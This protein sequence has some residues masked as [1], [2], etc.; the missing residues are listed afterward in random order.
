MSR[1][2]AMLEYRRYTNITLPGICCTALHII[3][4][5]C[6]WHSSMIEEVEIA[7]AT[8]TRGV[9][10]R[11]ASLTIR[12]LFCRIAPRYTILFRGL[13][14]FSFS[15]WAMSPVKLRRITWSAINKNRP[16]SLQHMSS[17]SIGCL[18]S[19]C[20]WQWSQQRCF[21][22]RIY[23]LQWRYDEHDGISNRRFLDCLFKQ[24]FKRRSK[25]TPKLLIINLCEW[26]PPVSGEFPS[27]RKC[28]HL[29]TSSCYKNFHSI[30]NI[31]ILFGFGS[32]TLTIKWRVAA[33]LIGLLCVCH[34]VS[35]TFLLKG[36]HNW[37]IIITKKH[38]RTT[39]YDGTQQ[40]HVLWLF[41]FQ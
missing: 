11:V 20:V 4:L 26:N 18:C 39:I 16:W 23:S 41:H 32:I 14:A 1:I 9:Y 15:G 34:S 17:F 25:K 35:I 36:K 38:I 7:V 37:V 31:V 24:F 2:Q 19:R 8:P 30:R 29:I 28:F 13:C 21:F 27:R 3:W 5:D 6:W 12:L 22:F 10:T 33:L 40:N